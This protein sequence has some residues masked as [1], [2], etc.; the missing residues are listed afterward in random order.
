[1]T[2]GTI[3]ATNERVRID[4]TGNVGIGDNTPGSTLSLA[5]SL[6]MKF[7]V[8]PNS[9][10][11][12]ATDYVIINTAAGAIGWNNPLASGCP[13]RI[14]RLVNQGT[15]IITLTRAVTTANATT[16]LFVPVGANFEI[17]SDGTVWRQIN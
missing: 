8:G 10:N 13:G 11:I 17:I 2:G 4:G 12:L 1:M 9:Y 7:V 5:G 6:E 14:Y 3:Q 16:T 15:G